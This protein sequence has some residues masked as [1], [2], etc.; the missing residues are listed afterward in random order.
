M[1]GLPEILGFLS[2][3]A[4]LCYA[5]RVPERDMSFDTKLVPAAL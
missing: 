2:G 3:L 4:R 1:N 5:E